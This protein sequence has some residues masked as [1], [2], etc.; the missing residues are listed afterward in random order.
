MSVI[1]H[2]VWFDLWHNKVR[3]LLAVLSIAVGVFAIGVVFSLADQMVAG[4][5]QAH[6]AVYP[7]HANMSLTGFIDQDVAASLK[8]IPGIA[9]VE[10]HNRIPVR[11]KL[12]PGGEW[13]DGL[14]VMRDDYENQT[15]DLVQLKAG[16]WPTKDDIGIERQSSK[17]FGL[18]IGDQV[19]FQIGNAERTFP[20]T[21]KI[22]HPFSQPPMFGGP[23]V[24]F[25]NK[26]GMERFGIPEGTY[27]SVMFR[28]EPYSAEYAKQVAAVVKDRLARQGVS[29]AMTIYMDPNEHWARFMLDGILIVLQVLAVVS[30]FMSAVLV[31]NTLTALITQ[32]TNQIGILK[33]IGGGTRTIVLVYLTGVLA[34][35]VMALTISLPLGVIAAFYVNRGFLSLLNIDYDVMTVSNSTLVLQVIAAIVIPLLAALLPTLSGAALTVRHAMSTYGLGGDFGSNWLDRAIERIGQRLLPAHYAIALGNLFRRK[36]RLLLTQLALIVAGVMFLIIMSLSSSVT[37]TL[38]HELARRAYDT[39][40]QFL[41]YQRIDRAV[42]TALTMDGV[43]KAEVWFVQP[44]TIVKGNHLVTETGK[45]AGQGVQLTGLPIGSGTYIP[46][47]VAG[48][49]LQPGDGQA[50]VMNRETAE[51]NQIGIGDT[52]TLDLGPLGRDDWQVV[53]LYQVVIGDVVNIDAIYASQPVVFDAVK[54]RN[55]GS[56]LYVQTRLHTADYAADVTTRLKDVFEG[57]KMDVFSGQTI[58]E[59]QKEATTQFS[60]VTG[61]MLALAVVVALV[62]GI[63]LMGALSIS[64][65]ERTKEIGVMRAIGAQSNAILGMFVMEGVLQGWL[66]WAVAVPVSF[67]L[68]PLLANNLGQVMFQINLDYQYNLVAAGIWLAIV[69][70]IS[71]LAS[72]LPARSATLISVRA[73]LAYA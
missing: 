53:G 60:I 57:R 66:S 29:V 18:E 51:D 63:G 13:K 6:Q 30:L 47:M 71:I 28:V 41:D 43:E 32:Q 12:K 15:Y 64:V 54:M 7:S 16:R 39:T 70:I 37:L 72:L 48:R 38:D 14:L 19:I 21:G 11:Y 26:R 27:S 10:P 2:K 73:S 36:A 45:Q 42:E 17:F 52:V 34:Y 9:N 46:L 61:M 20:I 4:M 22:R 49:W 25:V 55:R 56:Q 44:A 33:A 3:T 68:A 67:F 35:G 40:I 1:W 23:A 59:T 31:L 50:I 58:Y 69:S 8:K 62:G 24:F 65:V 5:N